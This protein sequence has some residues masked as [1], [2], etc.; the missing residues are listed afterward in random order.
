MHDVLWFII[1][2]LLTVLHFLTV[3][4]SLNW[5]SFVLWLLHVDVWWFIK[6]VFKLFRGWFYFKG[7]TLFS[8]PG[9][10]SPEI[11]SPAA[12]LFR[13]KISRGRFLGRRKY[14]AAPASAFRQPPPTCRTAFPRRAFSVAG[15]MAWNSLPDFIRDPTSSTDCFRHLLK[16]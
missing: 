15:P 8:L 3:F 12:N 10:F 11:K 2:I 6:P 7:A 1:R 4:C 13:A 16:T 9:G 14:F 5:Y